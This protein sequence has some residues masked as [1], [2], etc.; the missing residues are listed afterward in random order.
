MT[1]SEESREQKSNSPVNE[2]THISN[3]QML[4]ELIAPLSGVV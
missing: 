3:A 4:M 2:L 1:D